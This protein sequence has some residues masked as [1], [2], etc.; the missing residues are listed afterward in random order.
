[1]T[2]PQKSRSRCTPTLSGQWFSFQ[3]RTQS[4]REAK[5]QRYAFGIR[6]AIVG[7]ISGRNEGSEP[8]NETVTTTRKKKD[9][10]E[11]TANGVAN[12]VCTLPSKV[13]NVSLT[14][15]PRNE[16]VTTTRKKKDSAER[17]ANGV[18]NGVCTLPSKVQ[19]VSLTLRPTDPAADPAGQIGGALGRGL[20]DKDGSAGV[21]QGIMNLRNYLN[22]PSLSPSTDQTILGLCGQADHAFGWGTGGKNSTT[23]WSAGSSSVASQPGFLYDTAALPSGIFNSQHDVDVNVGG[24]KLTVR[25]FAQGGPS[26]GTTSLFSGST[27]AIIMRTTPSR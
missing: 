7:G 18:A 22:I 3:G 20:L 12:G 25:V 27:G 6:Q 4:S 11:R 26:L 16:T 13:H 1:M 2:T 23:G 10:A 9:S 8:R 19:N 15:R 24:L 5:I 14:L 17:T 21:A